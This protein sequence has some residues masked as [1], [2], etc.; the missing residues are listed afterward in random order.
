MRAFIQ[1]NSRDSEKV[2]AV[3]PIL[4]FIVLPSVVFIE[5][6]GEGI[7]LRYAR[8]LMFLHP[9]QGVIGCKN[10]CTGGL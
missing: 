10:I 5:L 3:S 2:F 9:C 6:S 8:T 7:A 1:I 4:L